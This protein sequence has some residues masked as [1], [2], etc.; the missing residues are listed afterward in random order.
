MDARSTASPS[1]TPSQ[2]C[3]CDLTGLRRAE[4]GKRRLLT[5]NM[6]LMQQLGAIPT[7]A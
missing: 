4:R 1:A 7:P 3:E 6:A 5:D 2:V